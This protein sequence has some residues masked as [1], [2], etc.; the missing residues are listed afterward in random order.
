[1][2][3]HRKEYSEEF[4]IEN[5][6]YIL[7]ISD[8]EE[9][10]YVDTNEYDEHVLSQSSETY[11]ITYVISNIYL[12]KGNDNISKINYDKKDIKSFFRK[13]AKKYV[14][15]ENKLYKGY[16]INEKTKS[17]DVYLEDNDKKYIIEFKAD[18]M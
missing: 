2:V 6:Y 3:E 7:Y 14:N 18:S 12:D 1:M 10:I 15:S 8:I 11:N 17:F 5:C 4:I 13:I 16:S 9:D